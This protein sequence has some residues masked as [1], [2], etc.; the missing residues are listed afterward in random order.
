[1]VTLDRGGIHE[2]E[3]DEPAPHSRTS[4]R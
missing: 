4:F 1:M 3:F 2:V